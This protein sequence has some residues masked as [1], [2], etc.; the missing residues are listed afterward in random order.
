MVDI[1]PLI[2]DGSIS[3]EKYGSMVTC[4]PIVHHAIK[5]LYYYSRFRGLSR[6]F[7]EV[8][9]LESEIIGSFSVA[10]LQ[11]CGVAVEKGKEVRG[12]KL[13]AEGE[14]SNDR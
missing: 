6:S 7:Q 1:A 2:V 10:V 12:W 4:H 14:I 3:I 13:E 5:L 11:S 9:A 8:S